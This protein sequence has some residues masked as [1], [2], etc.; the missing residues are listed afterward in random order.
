ML[1]SAKSRRLLSAAFVVLIASFAIGCSS[2]DEPNSP[3]SG[4]GGGLELNSPN[5]GP[6]GV[7]AHTMPATLTT[8]NYH[9]KIHSS[10]TASVIVATGG[11]ATASVSITDN[12][13]NPTSVTVGPGAVV[14][15]TNNGGNTHTV[16]SN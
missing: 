6:A 3:P 1:Q 8:Y 14:T 11:A 9:C 15:W 5:L 7:Y 4:G 16:T 2:N 13:F 12:A 10:M